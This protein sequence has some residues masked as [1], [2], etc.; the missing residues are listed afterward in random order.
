M[1]TYIVHCK[2]EIHHEGDIEIDAPSIEEAEAQAERY[3]GQEPYQQKKGRDSYLVDYWNDP[4]QAD[5]YD[6]SFYVED[7]MSEEEKE[8]EAEALRLEA[9][10]NS[11]N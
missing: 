6:M 1:S 8:E 11:S 10:E 4:L 3:M 2:V 7:G 5:V 9:E